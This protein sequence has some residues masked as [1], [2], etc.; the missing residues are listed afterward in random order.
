M[1][2]AI[3]KHLVFTALFA[4][5]AACSPVRKT[6]LHDDLGGK[7]GVDAIVDSLLNIFADDR[8]VGPFFANSNIPRFRRLFAQYLC[9]AS[10][11]GCDYEGDDMQE[12]HTGLGITDKSFNAV[13]EDLQQAMDQN[14]VPVRIQNRL[15]ARLAPQHKHIVGR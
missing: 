1:R 4:L 11:G 10:D 8:R 7:A 14:R 13:V 12:S 3:G 9:Q 2:S 5:C 6:T 15:L